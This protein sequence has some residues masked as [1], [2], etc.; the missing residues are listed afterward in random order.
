MPA[1]AER[2]K[3]KAV[4]FRKLR[5]SL[6]GSQAELSKAWSIVGAPAKWPKKLPVGLGYRKIVDACK[7]PPHQA[8]VVEF[9]VFVAV[10]AMPLPAVVCGLDHSYAD[11]A[12]GPT[13][14]V[15]MFTSVPAVIFMLVLEIMSSP[16]VWVHLITS[17][18]LLLFTTVLPIR[19]LKGWLVASHFSSRRK[20]GSWSRIEPPVASHRA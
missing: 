20:R 15:Q 1:T 13:F 10:R 16:P 19:P 5:P 3:C 8:V 11:P 17:L 14:F 2:A 18:P 4:I 6:G 9:P 12:D 7:P